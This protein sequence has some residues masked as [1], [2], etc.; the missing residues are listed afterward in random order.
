MEPIKDTVEN[1]IK[2][3]EAKSKGGLR[4][5]PQVLLKRIFTKKELDHV[6][7]NYFKGHTLNINVDSS[8]WLYHLNLKKDKLLAKLHKDS[9]NIIND[10]R[11]FVGEIS[12]KGKSKTP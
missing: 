7:F 5:N 8:S 6:K 9:G 12:E 10:I 2:K 4:H 1:V 11:F 3:W